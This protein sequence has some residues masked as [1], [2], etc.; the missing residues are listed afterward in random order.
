MLKSNSK[1]STKL[2]RESLRSLPLF[3]ELSIE[4]LRHVA[5]ISN[6][7]KFE[8]NTLIFKEGDSY[9][10]FYIL[11]KGSI[12]ISKYSS[13]GKESI[14]HLIKPPES[15]GDVPL[16]EGGGYPVNALA[17][18]NSTLLFIPKNEFLKLLYS[19]SS[20]SFQM[21]AG[22]AKRMRL[23]TRRIEDLTTKE[24]TSRLAKYLIE[25]SKKANTDKLAEPFVKLSVS[26]KN[27]AAYL[28]TINETLSRSL[29]KLQ[30]DGIVRCSGKTIFIV[31]PKQL[32]KIAE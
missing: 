6:I 5:A 1:I 16:F 21:L 9:K 10:G 2:S 22:F 19:D 7:K 18:T 13:G 14:F 3:S 20:L 25:E 26:K 23:L 32:K 17:T 11:L 30:D 12:K 31:N 24:V 27:I 29:K 8:K 15:F 28:G 4:H